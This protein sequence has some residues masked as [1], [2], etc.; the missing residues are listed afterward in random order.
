[1]WTVYVTVQA[2]MQK[3]QEVSLKVLACF[4]IGMGLDEDFFTQVCVPE[5]TKALGNHPYFVLMAL[6]LG[7]T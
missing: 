3:C 1:M 5:A 2:Y 7:Y 4:A 6:S